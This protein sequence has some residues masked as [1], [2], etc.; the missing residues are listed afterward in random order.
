MANIII[1]KTL[2]EKQREDLKKF[3]EPQIDEKI[4]Q[5]H[6]HKPDASAPRPIYQ[7]KDKV[8]F[9][10]GIRVY[11]TAGDKRCV[12]KG[13]IDSNMVIYKGRK[14]TFG[15]YRRKYANKR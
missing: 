13:E 3:I 11:N 14:M 5:L 2:A 12:A 1:G 10:N 7:S 8:V 6:P 9:E 4:R 15:E